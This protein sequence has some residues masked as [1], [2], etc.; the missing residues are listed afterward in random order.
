MR[1]LF[2]R[3]VRL[4][5]PSSTYWLFVSILTFILAEIVASIAFGGAPVNVAHA[6]SVFAIDGPTTVSHDEND[7]AIVATYTVTGGQ[8][9][10]GVAWG[11]DGT[12]ARRF[13]VNASGELSFTAARNFERPNDGNRDNIYEIQL[14]ATA[15]PDYESVDVS[16]T[17]QDVNEPPQ[18]DVVSDSLTIV[19]NAPANRNVGGALAA[20]DEDDGDDW[21]FSLSGDDAASFLIEEASGQIR[22]R[23]GTL[24]DYETNAE[25]MFTAT[26]TDLGGLS[27]SMPIS[28]TVLNEDD[29]GVVT[30]DKTQPTVGAQITATLSDDDGVVGTVRWRWSRAQSVDDSYALIQGAESATYTPA[31]PD[32]GYV[33]KATARYT[34]SFDSNKT[35]EAT[36]NV[37]LIN[38]PPAFDEGPTAT[39]EIGDGSVGGTEV[40]MPVSALDLQNDDLSYSISGPDADDFAINEDSGQISVATGKTLSLAEQA[41]HTVTVSVSDGKDESGQSDTAVDDTIAV[42]ISVVKVNHA[43]A[44][45]TETLQ[46]TVFEESSSGTNVGE[47]ITAM[48]SDDDV[49]TYAL[50]GDD[51]GKFTIDTTTGQISV[52]DEALPLAATE[53]EYTL[54]VT[55]TDPGDLSDTVAVTIT[56]TTPNEPPTITGPSAVDYAENATATVATYVATDPDDD[57]ASITLT[58]GGT[59][60]LL[61]ELSDTGALSFKASP[62]FETPGDAND[63]NIYEIT[64]TAS[65]GSLSDSVDTEVTV[66]NVNEP[67]SLTGL[68]DASYAENGT[69]SVATY[70]ASDVDSNTSITLT[71]GGTDA[72]RFEIAETGVLSF[73]VS[74][75]YETPG[76]ANGDNVF[77]ITVTASDGTLRDSVDIEVTVTNVN[78]SPSLTGPTDASYAENG[79]T[80]VAT[81][82]ASDVD[83]NTSITLTLG[84]PDAVRFEISETG[85][86]S[87][88]VSPDFETPGDANEDNV[89]EITVTA[90]DG[91][92]SDAVDIDVTVTNVNEPLAI[93]GSVS[94]S[95]A[96]NG[97]DAVVTFTADD[98]EVDDPVT[99]SLDGTDAASFAISLA[100]G[101]SF[102][103]S[104]NFEAPHDANQNNVYE[105]T[106]G[107][108]DGNSDASLDIEVTV[109][110]IGESTTITGPETV[111]YAENDT[112]TVATYI[113][114][115]PEM[116]GPITWTVGGTDAVRFSIASAGILSFTTAP[117]FERARD[118]NQDNNYEVTITAGDGDLSASVE[119]T[120]T[121][122]DVNEAP[123]FEVEAA[124]LSIAENAPGGRS[125]GVALTASDE[126]DGDDWTFSISGSDAGPFLIEASSGQ[127]RVGTDALLD[128][129]TDAEYVFTATATDLGGLSDSILITVSILDA[130]DPGVVGFNT[131][132]P[133]V[134]APITAGL[135]DDDGVVGNVGWQWS[136]APIADDPFEQIEGVQGATYTPTQLDLDYVLKAIATYTDS[137]GSNKTAEATSSAI[138]L[139]DPPQFDE[140]TAATREIAD[141]ST[142]KE[143]VGAPV[144][145]TD[146]EGDDLSYSLSGTDASN[147][148][149]DGDTGQISV[150]IDKT[151]SNAGQ[152][153]HTLTVSVND[154]KNESGQS[155]TTADDS[156]GVT[157]NVV[158]ANQPP[159]FPA[160]TGQRTVQEEAASGTNVGNPVTATDPDDDG[161]TYALSGDDAGKFTIDAATGQISVGD[162]ALPLAAIEA[163]YTVIVTA[164]DP[165]NL[166]DTVAVTITATTPGEP[167]TIMGP[168]TVNFVENGTAAVATYSVTDPD[169]TTITWS[170]DGTDAARFAIGTTGVLSFLTAPDFERALDANQDNTYEIAINVSGDLSASVDVNVT[171]T[172]INEIPT[173]TGPSVI[174]YAEKDE[175]AVAI[176]AATDPDSDTTFTWSVGGTDALRFEITEEGSLS[177]RAPPDFSRPSDSDEDNIYEITVTASDGDLSASID[178]MVTVTN[179]NEIPTLTGP[180][181][182]DYVENSETAVATYSVTD[183]DGDATIAWSVDGTDAARFKISEDGV[184]SFETPPNF[185]QPSDADKDNEYEIT[186]AATGGRL[187]ASLDVTV[188]VANAN[189]APSFPVERLVAGIP[190]N[191]CPGAYT[192]L[193]GIPGSEGLR[194]DEDGDPLTFALSGPDA[195][196]FVIHTPTGYVTLGP[197]TALDH[198]AVKNSYVLRVSV[199]DGRDAAGDAELTPVADDVLELVAMVT[200]VD[201]PPVFVEATL[202]RDNCGRPDGY[203][204]VQLER[205][206]TRRSPRFSPAGEPIAAIDPELDAISYSI[207]T[208]ETPPPFV[209]DP[210]SGQI[211]LSGTFDL[212]SRRRVYTVRVTASDGAQETAIETRIRIVSAPSPPRP[213]PTPDASNTERD[214]GEEAPPSPPKSG[215]SLAETDASDSDVFPSSLTVPAP[216][217]APQRFVQ[218][219]GA[220]PVQALT[221]TAMESDAGNVSL[222]APPGALSATYQVRLSEDGNHCADTGYPSGVTPL[223]CVAVELF[224][225]L[226]NKVPPVRFGRPVSLQFMVQPTLISGLGVSQAI[227]QER[228]KGSLGIMSLSDNMENWQDAESATRS[229]DDGAR[230]VATY[231]REPGRFMVVS[232]P[233]RSPNLGIASGFPKAVSALWLTSG[234]TSRTP[235]DL[236]KGRAGPT[237]EMPAFFRPSADMMSISSLRQGSARAIPGLLV[238]FFLDVTFV[239]M[240]ASVIYR[241]ARP[242]S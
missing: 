115:D 231:I 137:Y 131:S 214:S 121:V 119:V 12:D 176:Y 228:S 240:T 132:E 3:A 230:V 217:I 144:S 203:V 46:R 194:V 146:P 142:G 205:E 7:T 41:S 100:G 156:I 78:E 225:A 87:F 92:L 148:E 94:V 140:G 234:D 9:N 53:A 93:D 118:A 110:N 173:L 80:S 109:T 90:S 174:N 169:N 101:L 180:S 14:N 223:V 63:D 175:T 51:A 69:T 226:G 221:G 122:Q 239:L 138:R 127:I 98:P 35:V 199:A 95:Y 27:D 189:D 185:E 24:L 233:R 139:N 133:H 61:F 212:S 55:A 150:A 89:Y 72:L 71:L 157:I 32:A 154:G 6:Q 70:T 197:G 186:I 159:T 13:S 128:Y 85:V 209:I 141:G 15:G 107:A 88:K 235:P 25:Y 229:M 33:L 38:G 44:F 47:P 22:V 184:L 104:P 97:T 54:T 145:A 59:D 198:E 147:F 103:V 123:Q 187:S 213:E 182:I 124:S 208:A 191:S 220:M 65:D 102:N 18:F 204:P 179:V 158:K 125:V 188:T 237:L 81:Y 57:D 73:K 16:V 29:P 75:D 211:K 206:V 227:E 241:I 43:P 96:E 105:I 99:W 183:P 8:P 23:S 171:V 48:D 236:G 207:T 1:A 108:T 242:R 160:E 11:I 58:L 232:Q 116:A 39:R 210:A 74:P 163:E 151:L 17:I 76:D 224:D 129:E 193:R 52:G 196:S 170:I 167:P 192:I 91:T 219:A 149:I 114:I 77:E 60:A 222:S 161:L 152:A 178:V 64:L 162:E 82:T 200:D 155:D 202:Q 86:L 168:A 164:T 165:G 36:T 21:T 218:V 30:F 67:P 113:A 56:V 84:G 195:A 201:E 117:N 26:V 126:D 172:N 66:T 45:A 28:I 50:S 40:G 153:V 112:A 37:V 111:N 181:A 49:L 62:D 177:F 190:E 135:A 19:E 238:A 2:R 4:V 130:D 10:T 216:P 166:H 143:E 34:D 42:T 106:V 83:S 20:T 134:G 79:T 5:A 31:G 68:T 215:D 120:V 136:R